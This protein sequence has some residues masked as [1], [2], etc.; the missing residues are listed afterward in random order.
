MSVSPA[1]MTFVDGKNSRND[2]TVTNTAKRTQ[3][4]DVTPFRIA[5][6]GDFPEDLQT[7]PKPDEV[8]LL[9]APRR[10]ILKPNETKVIR[11]ILLDKD[12]M[13]D[14]AWRVSIKP[15]IGKVTAKSSGAM[16]N[17]AFNA[18]VIAR[19]ETPR[20]DLKGQWEGQ[21]LVLRNQGNTNT[22]I[23][24]GEQCLPSLPCTNI[25]VKRIWPGQTHRIDFT[26]RGYVNLTL[27]TSKEPLT[28]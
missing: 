18:L 28:F 12:I 14:K 17:M 26:H 4:L 21:T 1:V 15:V 9:V 22:R 19:P 5:R 10:I 11:T 3:Y 27:S 8:G 20:A 13:A 24:G 6:P 7:S 16:V 2:F 25:K 23:T